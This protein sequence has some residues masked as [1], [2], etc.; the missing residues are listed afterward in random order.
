MPTIVW[1]DKQ[2]LER[3]V[4]FRK[5]S[6]KETPAYL[7]SSSLARAQELLD[8][9]EKDDLE[10]Y[11]LLVQNG[12][13]IGQLNLHLETDEIVK[14]RLISVLQAYRG[15]GYGKMLLDKAVKVAQAEKRTYLRLFVNQK[16]ASAIAC[17]ERYGFTPIR[18]RYP[19]VKQYEYQIKP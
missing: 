9:L 7:S 2:Y 12:T 10:R 19:S 13:V 18:S 5:L 11:Y 16:N 3:F 8:G 4:T 1:F 15:K 6:H 14:L 17:Y